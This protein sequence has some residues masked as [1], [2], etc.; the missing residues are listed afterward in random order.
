M[1]AGCCGSPRRESSRDKP[2]IV[3]PYDP[4]GPVLRVRLTVAMDGLRA[5]DIA[6]YTGGHV[7]ALIAGKQLVLDD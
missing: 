3:G 1:S 6:Y 4:A 5:G 7:D 2:I